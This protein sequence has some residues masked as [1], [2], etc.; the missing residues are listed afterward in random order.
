MGPCRKNPCSFAILFALIL[1]IGHPVFS[2]EALYLQLGSPGSAGVIVGDETAFL[3]DGGKSG[4]LTTAEFLDEKSLMEYLEEKSIR[5][6][7]VSCSH[8]HSD[9]A[10]GLRDLIA[11]EAF[12]DSSFQ[13]IV[14]V[15]SGISVGK[16][17][18]DDL[19]K[20]HPALANVATHVDATNKNA[21]ADP[22]LRGLVAA[23]T[24]L[25]VW[26][27]EYQPRQVAHEHGKTII[28]QFLL[29]DSESGDSTL[30]VDFDDADNEL[31]A[32]WSDAFP[33]DRQ[34][35]RNLVVVSPH[36]NSDKSNIAPILRHM[37]KGSKDA[38]VFSVNSSNMYRHPGP[39]NWLKWIDHLGLPNVHVTGGSGNV[40]ISSHGVKPVEVTSFSSIIENVIL[41]LASNAQM[42]RRR[43]EEKLSQQS[44]E[45]KD[46]FALDNYRFDIGVCSHLASLYSASSSGTLDKS[47][48][49]PPVRATPGT[50]KVAIAGN[51]ARSRIEAG[52]SSRRISGS[53]GYK[54]LKGLS[55]GGDPASPRLERYERSTKGLP[56]FGGVV[57]GNVVQLR[58]DEQFL[59]AKIEFELI[60][61]YEEEE[62]IV[63]SIKITTDGRMGQR[64]YSFEHMTVTE[65]WCA[66]HILQP[67]DDWN[68]EYGVLADEVDIAG[69]MPGESGAK[70]WGFGIHPAISNTLLA[71][72][73]M[74]LDMAPGFAAT[75]KL[76]DDLSNALRELVSK[77]M[78]SYQWTDTKFNV[79]GQT[80]TRMAII[81]SGFPLDLRFRCWQT[82]LANEIASELALIGFETRSPILVVSGFLL[83]LFDF[84]S[85]KGPTES[86]W[87]DDDRLL[88]IEELFPPAE[89]LGSLARTLAVLRIAIDNNIDLPALPA[90]LDDP[91]LQ[92]VIPEMTMDEVNKYLTGLRRQ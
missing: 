16:R 25:D 11:S 67:K 40:F 2:A 38:V 3:V 49:E 23:E 76:E 46:D 59:S 65:L 64:T 74:L 77:R 18:Y 48:L 81:N 43:R 69:K 63:P 1:G 71:R 55:P 8:P 47:L 51:G 58:D 60:E 30:L 6:L 37:R 52:D 73:A 31:I 5:N 79:T 19:L 84:V 34:G 32:K 89:R 44:A 86:V 13:S 87:Q 41:P 57:F 15:D 20:A 42:M 82:T 10:G 22:A 70:A 61:G 26:N 83:G 4:A 9:H 45:L 12:A 90:K 29:E 39:R 80:P 56:I 17:L 53:G 50:K 27:F 91:V 72:D 54:Q 36:H 62:V 33:E 28:S 14:F 75:S 35:A 66:Y 85:E 68:A 78:L 21:Y 24:N 92:A 7:V 88:Q